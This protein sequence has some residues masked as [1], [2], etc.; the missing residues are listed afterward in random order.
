MKNILL[1]TIIALFSITGLHS[2]EWYNDLDTAKEMA[3]TKDE[4]IILVFQ[5]SDW[6]APCIKLDRQIWSTE[7]FRNYARDHYIMLKADFPRKSKN[8]LPNEQAKKNEA[9]AA[10]Y[11]KSGYFPF[12]VI[13]DHQGEVL[14]ETGFKNMSPQDYINHINSFL[15]DAD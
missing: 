14:G 9:L 1:L 4:P 10:R 6:C 7:E 15:P 12:V 11:N 3:V 13:L 5:G 8:Q 2:Q